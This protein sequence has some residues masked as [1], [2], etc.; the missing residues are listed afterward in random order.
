[1][2]LSKA[3]VLEKD[4]R[5]VRTPPQRCLPLPVCVC[6][7]LKTTNTSLSSCSTISYEQHVKRRKTQRGDGRLLGDD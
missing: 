2:S 3:A 5:S 1:M 7:L 4:V 6:R